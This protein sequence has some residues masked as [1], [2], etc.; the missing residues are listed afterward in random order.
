MLNMLGKELVFEGPEGV[1][2]P[3]KITDRWD[4]ILNNIVKSLSG[5]GETV[6]YSFA[7]RAYNNPV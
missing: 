1:A 2:I 3:L 7:N 5:K 4:N 6:T